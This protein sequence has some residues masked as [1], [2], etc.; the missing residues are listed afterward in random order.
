MPKF[1]LAALGT[2]EHFVFIHQCA[3][4][5]HENVLVQMTYAYKAAFFQRA[6]HSNRLF[7]HVPSHFVAVIWTITRKDPFF[8]RPIK[9]FYI[10]MSAKLR[11]SGLQEVRTSDILKL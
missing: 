2:N 1:R 9:I 7:F 3:N 5:S 4:L 10:T 11:T 8:I 6:V